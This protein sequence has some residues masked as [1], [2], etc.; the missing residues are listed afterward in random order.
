MVTPKSQLHP[1][2]P[3]VKSNTRFCLI[4]PPSIFLLD[5]RVFASL[6]ILRVAAT[7][8]ARD[9]YV[10]V[11]DLSGITNYEEVAALHAKSSTANIFGVTATTP[12]MPAAHNIL[13]AIKGAK[14][15]AHMLLGGPH[16]TL[17]NAAAKREIE[18]N[19]KGRAFNALTQ[20]QSAWNQIVAGDG[21]KAILHIARGD[22]NKLIDA[23]KP[24]E[25]LF[26]R[27][28]QVDEFPFP[29]RHLI[30]MASYHYKIDGAPSTSLIA[31]L[32]CPFNCFFCGG[33]YS[34]MLRM[35]RTRSTPSIL[36]EV[37]F[38]HQKFGYTGLMF[39]DDELNVNKEMIQLMNGLS[40]LQAKLGVEFKLRGFIKAELFTPEQ[41]EAMHRAG[42]RWILTG[43]ES[44]SPRILTNIDKK[45]TQDDNTRCVDIARA[46]GLKVKALMSIGHAG[47]S[48]QTCQE[49]ADW[50][51]NVKPEDFDV[52]IITTY[53]GSPYYDD[54][55]QLDK[56]KPIYTF[57][58]P[59]TGDRLHS[60]EIDYN[61]VA[62][63]YKGDPDG[64]YQA[65]VH[66]DFLTSDELVKIR[67]EMEGGIRARL[68]LPWNP[69][70]A[71][72]AF[73]HSMGQL[74]P[75]ILRSTEMPEFAKPKAFL[76]IS[77]DAEKQ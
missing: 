14:P 63:Y 30:D 50:V 13:R 69:S 77:P 54:A 32:G 57:T 22:R 23:D 37:E 53:P 40:D 2:G 3:T 71:S 59:K 15:D 41:A 47:E 42:F 24:R 76:D 48:Q 27:K 46:A 26:I 21:E 31:Q 56:E 43:F 44:G 45:A 17:I 18:Q 6:G 66:T 72:Q 75:S 16:P 73:E 74:P 65:Y 68:N 9:Y 51:L 19:R 25:E 28:G 8:E 34:P 49:T 29:A 5:E 33:R 11:L 20:L 70:A 1:R 64:G 39:Y 36:A 67:G 55:V 60:Q 7:L 62:D 58:H 4:I 52:A 61:V 12:Q 10:E 38:L 35:S